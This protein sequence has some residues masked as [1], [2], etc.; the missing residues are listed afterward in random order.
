[1]LRRET[2]LVGDCFS[3]KPANSIDLPYA[4]TT[5]AAVANTLLLWQR[6]AARET[7]FD[8]GLSKHVCIFRARSRVMA[9][10]QEVSP[11]S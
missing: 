8:A 10:R 9:I 7:I 1:M 5:A 6:S 11:I 3:S 4:A 2:F